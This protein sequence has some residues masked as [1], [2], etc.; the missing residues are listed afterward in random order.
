MRKQPKTRFRESA[1]GQS[2]TTICVTG[3][4]EAMSRA[5]ADY[6]VAELSRRPDALICLATGATLIR[7]YEL[8]AARGQA[9]P[10]LLEKAGFLKLDEWGG[11]PADNVS[12]CEAYLRQKLV[13][14]LG[15]RADQFSGWKC[16]PP[17]PAAECRRIAGWLA[18]HGPIDVSVL[19]LGLNGHLGLNEPGP[20]LTAGPHVAELTADSR[21]HSMLA[22]AGAS[23]SFGFTLG[24]ADILQS[25]KVLLVVSGASKA[26]AMRR[27]ATKQIS[28]RFPASL[29]WLHPALTIIC[30]RAAA[31]LAGPGFPA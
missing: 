21:R 15:L 17:D 25:R 30:D 4:Y 6:L 13:R 1:A 20:A 26:A 31:A 16:Q 5:A 8:L 10:T 11:L 14:P 3:D 28:T 23:V 12:S 2:P 29:L 9:A 22:G 27:L 7:T 18:Q 24:M 19:G